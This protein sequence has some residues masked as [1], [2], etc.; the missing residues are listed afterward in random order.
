MNTKTRSAL[1]ASLKQ[2]DAALDERLPEAESPAAKTPPDAPV[3]APERKP[4][5]RRAPPQ[6]R[7]PAK[8]VAPGIARVATA[9]AS[10]PAAPPARAASSIPAEPRP[11]SGTATQ[12]AKPS[13]PKT[14]KRQRA[15]FS[16]AASDLHRL[17]ALRSAMK[18]AGRPARKSEL[19]RAGLAAL[20]ALGHADAV[21]LLDALPP[22]KRTAGKG[23]EKGKAGKKKSAKRKAAAR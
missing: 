10:A 13:K 18:A 11:R 4:R 19:V 15:S 5:A 9:A 21:A 16:L 8:T 6:G 12:A 17:D 20:T 23:D 7:T 22:L 1:R 14:E 3:A 2:E